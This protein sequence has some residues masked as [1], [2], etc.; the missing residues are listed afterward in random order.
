MWNDAKD[1]PI[2]LQEAAERS[3]ALKAQSICE[4]LIQRMDKEK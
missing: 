2:R 1:F 4:E 3:D